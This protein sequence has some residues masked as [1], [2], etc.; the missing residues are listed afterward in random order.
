MIALLGLHWRRHRVVMVALAAGFFAF[1]WVVTRFAPGAEQAELMQQL[2][3]LMP[4]GLIAIAGEELVATLTARGMLGFG[5]QHPFVFI[6][7]AAWV[8]RVSAASLAGEIDRGTMDLL[9]VRPVGRSWF[10][11]AGFIA[12][13]AGLTVIVAAG[14]G[15]MAYGL[16][17]RPQLEVHGG[18]YVPVAAGLWLTMLAFGAVGFAISA[19]RR[20]AGTAIGWTSGVVAVSFV[21]DYVAKAWQPAAWLRP[22][23]LFSHLTPRRI[24]AEGLGAQGGSVLVMLLTM[25]AALTAA[26]LIFERRDL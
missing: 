16:A 19:S 12:M 11:T 23:S 18:E 14:W 20:T 24:L 4:R 1:G 26:Y 15:G 7:T 25:A 21:L 10:V 5:Y 6:M 3:A 22:V 8:V 2:F 17:T 9:A 13:L